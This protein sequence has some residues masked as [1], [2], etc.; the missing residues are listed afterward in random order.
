MEVGLFS[1]GVARTADPD[2]V[3][4][5]ARTADDMG[6]ASLWAPEH[7]VLFAQ[8][9]YTSRYPYNE[10]GKI[11][12]TD[13]DLLDPFVTLAFAAA[14][15]SRIKLATGICLVPQRNPLI[16]A[17]L[18]ASLDRLSK[19]RLL[20]G[21]GI[22]WLTEEFQALGIPPERRAQRTCEYLEVMRVLWTQDTPSFQG[23]FCAFPPVKSFPKPIQ[24]PHP[25][26]IFGG[27]TV[28]ALRRAVEVGDGWLGFHLSSQEAAP[29]V[30]RLNQYATEAGRNVDDL[31]IGVVANAPVTR[32]G[33]QQYRHAGVRHL[34]VR[35]PTVAPERLEAA[36]GELREH[37]VVPAQSL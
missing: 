10:S 11:S 36:L 35:L 20:F 25:P 4:Q 7:V 17:K 37:L 8:D 15:T 23:E 1:I 31:F 30:Q 28:P 16:T 19:G 5:I 34:V 18:V 29:L 13:A 12:V 2:I 33:L 26:I 27:H 3:G 9:S 32:E 24:K 22:G 14:H 6:F 21:V